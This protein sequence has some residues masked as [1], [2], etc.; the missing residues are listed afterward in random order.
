MLKHREPPSRSPG[1]HYPP[2]LGKDQR[3]G[4]GKEQ[5]EQQQQDGHWQMQMQM[6]KMRFDDHVDGGDC[7]DG[8]GEA[9]VV[10]GSG[11]TGQL[12]GAGAKRISNRKVELH[13]FGAGKRR[14]VNNQSSSLHIG[15]PRG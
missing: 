1:R 3:P 2:P 6:G 15:L 10:A 9:E 14:Q 13:S 4:A 11:R 7:V 5:Q 8:A 12:D